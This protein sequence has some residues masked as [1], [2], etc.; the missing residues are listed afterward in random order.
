M[1]LFFCSRALYYSSGLIAS[2][3][4]KILEGSYESLFD[5]H[6]TLWPENDNRS[7]VFIN[8]VYK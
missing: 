7:G 1:Y 3:P 5:R 6:K 4:L 2:T 8:V